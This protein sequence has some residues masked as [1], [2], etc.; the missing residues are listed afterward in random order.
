V[1]IIKKKIKYLK[2]SPYNPRRD[3]KPG[4]PAYDRLKKSIENF[5][6]IEPIVWNKRTDRVVGGHQR[7]KILSELGYEDVEVSV[8]DLDEEKEKALNLALNKTGGNW[9]LKKLEI[10][11]KDLKLTDLDFEMT[12]FSEIEVKQLGKYMD[13]NQDSSPKLGDGLEYQIIINCKDEFHQIK[14]LKKFEKEKIKCRP[15]IL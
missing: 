7:I 12:G 2:A 4:N 8:V 15:L 14:L 1:Q 11:F 5:N 9:D 10:V 6:Y 13:N 3:L